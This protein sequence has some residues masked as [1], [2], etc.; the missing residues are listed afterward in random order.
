MSA[1]F[2]TGASRGI[3][4][5]VT[6]ALLARGDAVAAAVR[7]PDSMAE[8]SARYGEK[9]WAG[10]LDVRQAAEVR[11]VVRHAFDTF[12]RIDVV[13]SNAGYGVYAAVE[14]LSDEQV[15]GIVAT[16]LTGSINVARSALPL[17]REQGG[18]RIIQMSSMAGHF[19]RPGFAMYHATKWGVEG[20][21]EALHDE[22]KPFGISTTVLAPG[23]FATGF[24]TAADRSAAHPAYA[25][26]PLI[27]RAPGNEQEMPGDTRL[28]V[29]L[30]LDVAAMDDPPRRLLLGSDA[31]RLA[32]DALARRLH[33]LD[34]Q[35]E[36]AHGTDR[37]G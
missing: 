8:L 27:P 6:E 23:R 7:D 31:Y 19:G 16:N 20:F 2:I 13:L 35:R 4:R 26:H 9:L 29:D 14:E 24:Y 32:R 25:S 30:I 3:G 37:A 21:Y 17:L 18:G 1:W 10:R 33:E 5:M 12:G 36:I 34:D 22:V 28:L 11:D 15:E